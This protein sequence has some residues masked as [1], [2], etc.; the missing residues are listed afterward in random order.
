MQDS[1]IVIPDPKLGRISIPG[2]LKEMT[3]LT[4][5][6]I[7]A[8]KGFKLEIWDAASY[9]ENEMPIT[10]YKALAQELSQQR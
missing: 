6:V 5:E 7:F 1:A 10:D 4:K 9:R 8:G 2:N 3:G